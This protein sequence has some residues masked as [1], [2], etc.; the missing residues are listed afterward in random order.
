MTEERK[1]RVVRKGRTYR[2]RKKESRARSVV[3]REPEQL[4]DA[5]LG[6]PT[7]DPAAIQAALYG[8][9]YMGGSRSSTRIASSTSRVA[10][11]SPSCRQASST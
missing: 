8:D 1:K 9:I 4:L 5:V 11:A 6:A 7:D 3:L 10:R 2:E